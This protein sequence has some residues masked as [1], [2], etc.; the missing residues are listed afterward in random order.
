MNENNKAMEKWLEEIN[1]FLETEAQESPLY[2]DCCGREIVGDD[3]YLEFHGDIYCDDCRSEHIFICDCC[4]ELVLDEDATF[5]N[6]YVY[7]DDCIDRH[8]T[9]CE[10]CGELVRINDSYR[11]VY[12]G[13]VC[14]YCYEDNY[15]YCPDCD[16]LY[17][18][19]DMVW[20]EW[21][22]E[23][24]CNHCYEERENRAIHEYSYKPN[25]IFYGADR[26]SDALF[27]G[28]E[29]EIDRGGEDNDNAEIL[30][31]TMNAWDEHI[32]IK[33][34][35]S[36]NNGFEIVSHP[37]TLNYHINDMKWLQLM[38]KALAMDYRSHDTETCGL[39]VHVSRRALGETYDERENTIAKII[40][41]I[42][43]NWNEIVKFT[44]RNEYTINRWARRY[45]VESTI[46]DTYEK[47]KGEYNRYSALNLLNDNTIEFRIFRGTLN[48]KTFAATL[49]FVNDLCMICKRETRDIIS[50]LTWEDFVTMLPAEHVELLEYL[51]KRNL[52]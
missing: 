40:Y 33:H 52:Y 2:C 16:N 31:D 45:G 1:T 48:H 19:D 27:M 6:D 32:Y 47:V 51:E 15:R 21:S 28:V 4:G 7:C 35:G 49:Q 3:D 25:P 30:L 41:F 39:H 44:R 8:F 26:Y 22:E 43:N 36:L 42:E 11:T 18:I 38:Q 20:D 10:N 50:A 14:D 9:Q 13:R 46:A 34:D 23:Y 37:A 5:Y 24:V 12:G 17:H 29:L